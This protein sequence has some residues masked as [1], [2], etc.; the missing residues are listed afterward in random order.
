MTLEKLKI[1][2]EK[3]NPGDFKEEIKVL[4]NPSEI[5]LTFPGVKMGE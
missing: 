4:F 5:S 3:N 1:Y 2:A